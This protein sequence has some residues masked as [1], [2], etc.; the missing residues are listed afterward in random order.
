MPNITAHN[1]VNSPLA[2]PLIRSPSVDGS[3]PSL[4]A[5]VLQN[6]SPTVNPVY[7]QAG[8]QNRTLQIR[9]EET[10][11]NNQTRR[12]LPA[13]PSPPSSLDTYNH[14]R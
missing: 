9:K 10:F 6:P 14:R 1:R 5:G 7:R 3:C 2:H 11:S 4:Q 13:A 12:Q 8:N